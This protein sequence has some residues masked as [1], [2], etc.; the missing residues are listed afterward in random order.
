M[1]KVVA[2][3]DLRDHLSVEPLPPHPLGLM[4]S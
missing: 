3:D 2:D 4:I 1:M